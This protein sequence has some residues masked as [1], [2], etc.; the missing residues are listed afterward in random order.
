M[1]DASHS[2]PVS[3]DVLVPRYGTFDTDILV[4]SLVDASVHLAFLESFA[5]HPVLAH[6]P[7]VGRNAN[8]CLL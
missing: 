7:L 2:Y 1:G 3:A 4:D 5:R 8:R 6:E